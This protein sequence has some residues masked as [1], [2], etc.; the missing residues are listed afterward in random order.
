MGGNC[1]G[2]YRPYLC[3]AYLCQVDL[4]LCWCSC[5]CWCSHVYYPLAASAGSAA[6]SRTCW[7]CHR[8]STHVSLIVSS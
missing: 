7:I 8:E 2:G 3:Q 6:A 5:L 1:H 4:G